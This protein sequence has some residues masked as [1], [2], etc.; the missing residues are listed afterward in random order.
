MSAA[1]AAL[2]A[3][4]RMRMRAPRVS[5]RLVA[6]AVIVMLA[7]AGG[8]RFYL[9]DSSLVAVSNVRVEGLNPSLPGASRLQADLERAAREMTTLD[10]KP[11]LLRRAAAQYP[12]VRS[13]SATSS[14]PHT[15]T[16]SVLER[17]PAAIIGEGSSAIVVADDGVVLRGMSADNLELPSLSD[18]HPPKGAR[19]TGNALEGARV[20]GAVPHALAPYVD[21][22]VYGS[23]GVAVELTDGIELR[24]GNSAQAGR[25]W[26]AAAGVLANPAL[27]ALDYVDLTAPEFPAV[28]GSSHLLPSAP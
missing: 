25:K 28:G 24:F 18:V 12:L 21:R 16:V 8:Y 15:L 9:R 1:T 22:A 26:A 4:P 27:T 14:F 3:R 5:R 17:R 19:I 11:E 20:L 2:R 7:L 13:V 10:V 6:F 23:K